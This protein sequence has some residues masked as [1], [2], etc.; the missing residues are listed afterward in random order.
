MCV[1]V[2]A[3][4]LFKVLVTCHAGL[5]VLWAWNVLAGKTTST[6]TTWTLLNS[7]LFS[8]D[9]VNEG[10]KRTKELVIFLLK[11]SIV[12]DHHNFF[13]WLI[14]E[15]FYCIWPSHMAHQFCFWVIVFL[16]SLGYGFPLFACLL[17]DCC[18][19]LSS[20]ISLSFL[21]GHFSILISLT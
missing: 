4:M 11:H 13:Q 15:S 2:V 9:S 7:S 6:A 5:Y 21:L 14:S 17:I 19:V 1:V 18:Y 8:D 12:Y 10:S 16:S 3:K 20:E